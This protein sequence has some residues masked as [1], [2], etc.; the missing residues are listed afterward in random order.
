[1]KRMILMAVMGAL[2]LALTAGMALAVVKNGG[3]GDD[4][5][6]GTS[7]R[8][9]LDGKKGDDKVYGRGG[10][11]GLYGHF[12]DDYIQGGAGDDHLDGSSFRIVEGDIIVGIEDQG[13][14]S[15]HGGTGDDTLQGRVGPDTLFSDAGVDIIFGNEGRDLIV[16]AEEIYPKKGEVDEVFCGPGFDRVI[17]DPNDKVAKD[18]ESVEFNKPVT[19]Q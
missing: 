6:R 14:D 2:M 15:M 3:P 8:D 9:H 12:G 13:S 11:D 19:T 17:V 18:C 7:A 1:M 10:S 16:S 4:T 5:L